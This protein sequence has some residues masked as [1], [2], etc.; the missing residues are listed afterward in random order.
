MHA[1]HFTPCSGA[2]GEAFTL[3]WY[4]GERGLNVHPFPQ[5]NQAPV[6]AK[7][8]E[9]QVETPLDATLSIPWCRE[10]TEAYI[11]TPISVEM[12]LILSQKNYST[13]VET[14]FLVDFVIGLNVSTVVPQ[15]SERTAR[16]SM[17]GILD[18]VAITRG[19]GAMGRGRLIWVRR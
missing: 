3:L 7:R 19:G 12:V 4:C 6:A 14:M 15:S 2:P 17:R 11:N 8:T 9:R 13:S 16:D 10:N 1:N 5:W 18:W